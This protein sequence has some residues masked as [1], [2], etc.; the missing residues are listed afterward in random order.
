MGKEELDLNVKWGIGYKLSVI[1]PTRLLDMAGLDIYAAVSG[2][3]S[4]Y[5]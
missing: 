1:G 4:M 2:W 5:S 3:A